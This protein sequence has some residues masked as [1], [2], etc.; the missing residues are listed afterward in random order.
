M[1]LKP[2][3]E[4]ADMEAALRACLPL[5]GAW[6]GDA[7]RMA[8][9]PFAT[10][11]TILSGQGAAARGGRW[12]PS[13]LPT[14]YACLSPQLAMIE[15]AAQR[16]KAGMTTRRHKPLTQITVIA[17]L[18]HV[19]DFRVSGVVKTFGRPL[20]PL[21]TEP[22]RS[23]VDGD[24]EILAQAVGRLAAA[25]GLEALIVPSVQDAS[26]HNLVI[27]REN[28]I[29]ASTLSIHGACYLLP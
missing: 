21:L 3:D 9:A 8:E 18:H 5:A 13:G 2:H 16:A 23:Q 28:L 12:N 14:V 20:T 19:L 26:A 11:S 6:A 10:R 24:A 29:P 22:H 25:L 4:S 15:W 7:F 1:R 27:F 17:A